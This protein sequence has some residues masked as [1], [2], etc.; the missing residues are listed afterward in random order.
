MSL[1]AVSFFM[2]LVGK[3]LIGKVVVFVDEEIN[4][5]ACFSTFVA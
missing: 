4:L 1:L 3:N 5:Q 2:L